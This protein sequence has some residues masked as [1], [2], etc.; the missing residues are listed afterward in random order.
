MNRVNILAVVKYLRELPDHKY[1]NNAHFNHTVHYYEKNGPASPRS[2]FMN[3]GHQVGPTG[4]VLVL[5]GYKTRYSQAIAMGVREQL[6]ITE[7]Q[8]KKLFYE[9]IFTGRPLRPTREQFAN[10]LEYFAGTGVIDWNQ[11]NRGAAVAQ[12]PILPAGGQPTRAGDE[13]T[14]ALT[15]KFVCISGVDPTNGVFEVPGLGLFCAPLATAVVTKARAL[16]IGDRVAGDGLVKGEI[17]HLT[18]DGF[19]LVKWA[20]ITQPKV[21]A[22]NKLTVS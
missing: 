12:P 10:V 7:D 20:G 13:C 5:L 17:L 14:V 9:P 18:G 16:K 11:R 6:D 2:F 15:A 1:I 21:H 3:G 8:Y 22:I 19:A 4:A